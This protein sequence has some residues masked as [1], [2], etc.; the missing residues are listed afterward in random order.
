MAG[1]RDQME[2]MDFVDEA[3]IQG[4]SGYMAVKAMR[5]AVEGG[6][7]KAGLV[8]GQD[9]V[10]ED[11]ERV[12]PRPDPEKSQEGGLRLVDRYGPQHDKGTQE[13]E[14]GGGCEDDQ[15]QGAWVCVDHLGRVRVR[16]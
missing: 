12:V 6:E 15:E 4:L 10:R 14:R 16:R 9:H 5:E 1:M 2:E 8:P 7:G 3:I 13:V 11:E